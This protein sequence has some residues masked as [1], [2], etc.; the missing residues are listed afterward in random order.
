MDLRTSFTLAAIV[1]WTLAS[2][3]AIAAGNSTIY[4]DIEGGTIPAA[5]Y[6][7]ASFVQTDDRSFN[8]VMPLTAD[9]VRLLNVTS[10]QLIP[11]SRVFNGRISSPAGQMTTFYGLTSCVMKSASSGSDGNA[12]FAFTCQK[13]QI[14]AVPVPTPS[15]SP[16]P[17]PKPTPTPVLKLV[18]PLAHPAL[19]T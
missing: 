9:A 17:T 4:I 15:P 3:P 6:A 13:S 16:T 19:K 12:H 2:A 14:S 1:G 10:Q 7:L 18:E 5:T 8:V 11:E